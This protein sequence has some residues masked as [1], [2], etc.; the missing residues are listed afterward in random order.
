MLYHKKLGFPESVV[1]PTIEYRL[2]YTKHAKI[3]SRERLQYVRRKEVPRSL[4]LKLK[5]IVELNLYKGEIIGCTTR[6][7]HDKK[8]DIVLILRFNH[9]KKFARVI[10][11]WFNERSDNHK[12]LNLKKYT[13]P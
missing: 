7:M 4:I 11:L 1:I 12:K 3:R 8:V 13:L 9:K 5:K 6:L 10:T 2:I